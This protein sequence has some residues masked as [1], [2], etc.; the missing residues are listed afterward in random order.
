MKKIISFGLQTM[1]LLL[2]SIVGSFL[3]PFHV[4]QITIISPTLTHILVWDGFLLM[5]LVY[6]VIILIA[7]L[8]KRLRSALP[9]TSLALLV[10][11]LLSVV[12]KLG[13]ITS[14]L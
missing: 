11:T 4:Q 13:R 10:A 14:E 5:F 3:R 6:V 12:M 7:A 9:L 1:L 2:C 8:S